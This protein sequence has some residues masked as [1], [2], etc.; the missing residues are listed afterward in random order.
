MHTLVTVGREIGERRAQLGGVIRR[1][2]GWCHD[3]VQRARRRAPA[4]AG[5]IAHLPHRLERAGVGATLPLGDRA[6][7]GESRV[8]P[9]ARFL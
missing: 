6:R 9:R 1:G 4:Q 7:L 2:R 8:E 3:D 5:A